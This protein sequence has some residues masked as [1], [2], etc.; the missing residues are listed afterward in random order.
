MQKQC[1]MDGCIKSSRRRGWCEAHYTR[2]YRNGSPTGGGSSPGSAQKYFDEVVLRH[3]SDECL[4]WPYARDNKGYPKVQKDGKIKKVTRVI[5]EIVNGAPPSSRHQ[6]AHSCGKGHLGCCAPKHLRW[7][8]PK[9]NAQDR[10]KHGT[11]LRGEYHPGT[12]LSE[13]EVMEIRAL[14]GHFSQSRLGKKFG[15]SRVA[16]G[17]IHRGERWGWLNDEADGRRPQ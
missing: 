5:C 6:A 3:S 7:A 17:Q 8:T 15:V 16:I 10:E 11:V 4:M 13:A 14:K 2:W 12:T 9:E 1:S